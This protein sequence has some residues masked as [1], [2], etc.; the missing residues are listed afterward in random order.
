MLSKQREQRHDQLRAARDAALVEHVQV[1]RCGRHV[2]DQRHGDLD[3]RLQLPEVIEVVPSLLLHLVVPRLGPSC[4]LIKDNSD[5][6]VNTVQSKEKCYLSNDLENTD[7]IFQYSVTHYLH[8][9]FQRIPSFFRRYSV[10][11][12]TKKCD[13]HNCGGR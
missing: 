3:L 1:E 8:P 4:F 12:I 2:L 11:G 7:N 13:E 9:V 6:A 10:N 5:S